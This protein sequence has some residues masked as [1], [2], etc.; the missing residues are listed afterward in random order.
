MRRRPREPG[1]IANRDCA[2]QFYNATGGNTDLRPETARNVT[3]GLV[4]QPLRDLIRRPG[5]LVDQDRQPDRR[6]PEAAIFADPQAYA[7]R[8]VRKA[9]GSIDHVVTGLAN[10]GKVKTSGVD[11]SLDYRFPGQPLRGS[12]GLD[13]QGTTCPAT[14]S[15]SR[16]AASTW[17]TSATS[18]ASA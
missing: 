5:L 12:S 17:T 13:L 11:L 7:G 6:V 8:I 9:D 15:S 14:T 16:S 10:L 2:Q 18:R 1:G 4:Y 3:L